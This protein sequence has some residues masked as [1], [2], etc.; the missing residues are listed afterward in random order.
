MTA[1]IAV[2]NKS[3]VALA[4]DSAGTIESGGSTKIYKTVDKIFELSRS[5]PVGVMI[6]GSLEF[7]GLPL[8][9]I[10]KEYRRQLTE[11]LPTIADYAEDFKK[12]L[13][14]LPFSDQDE[15]DRVV[16]IL[17]ASFRELRK[18]IERAFLHYSSEQ[19]KVRLGKLN[20]FIENAIRAE[21]VEYKGRDYPTDFYNRRPPKF[22]ERYE[23]LFDYTADN[24]FN[25]MKLSSGN[26]KLLR[27][28]G[29]EILLRRPLS[30]LRTGI[31][32]AGFGRD[33]LCPTLHSFEIDGIIS[34]RLK[35]NTYKTIDIGREGPPA[36]M[37][38]FAQDDMV[39][40]FLLGV[41][42]TYNEYVS[43]AVK[44]LLDE[45]TGRFRKASTPPSPELIE[46]ATA[47][48]TIFD[49]VLGELD[50]KLKQYRETTF[51]APTIELIRFMP[52]K[53]LATLAE[54]M[55]ELTS[56][57]R[58]VSWQRETVGGD[59]DVAVISKSEGFVWVKR[60]HYFPGELNPRFFNR[61]QNPAGGP[62]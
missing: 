53:E 13:N 28:L 32:I 12:Y 36:D 11:P 18:N 40:T 24:V 6:Y 27:R 46:T 39:E 15:G 57:K 19:G 44:S 5:E 26:K 9:S 60:K 55:I 20:Q 41:D 34:N 14:E 25:G 50:V 37:V 2:L 35:A 1:E 31:V 30:S 3:A 21:L 61:L 29:V 45:I 16:R 54:S 58:R 23:K 47:L 7:M 51:R 56:L 33:E 48:D 49:K 62:A 43:E 17:S 8:D 4:A 10:I 38:G 52:K 22:V 42:P 59:V